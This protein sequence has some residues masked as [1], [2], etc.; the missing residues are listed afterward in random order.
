MR[1]EER[2]TIRRKEGDGNDSTMGK[3]EEGLRED[4]WTER[5]MISKRRDC[6]GRKCTTVLRV[7]V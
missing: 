1:R 4:G 2:S 3:G 5:G 6:R 7:G